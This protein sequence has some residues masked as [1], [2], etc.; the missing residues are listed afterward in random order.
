MSRLGEK[1]AQVRT[2]K[3][4]TQKVLAKK[5]GVAESFIKDIELGRKV[6]NETLMEKVSKVLGEEVNDVSMSFDDVVEAE[7]RVAVE[8]KPK[9]KTLEK[10]DNQWSD[11][12]SSVL[13][14]VPVYGYDLNK[15]IDTKQLPVVS[16]KINGYTPDKVI[17]LKIENDDMLSFRIAEGDIAF[18]NL[19][20]EIENNTICLVECRG[21]RCLRQIKKLDS[22]KVLLISNKNSLRADAFSKKEVKVIAKLNYVE[23]KL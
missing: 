20:G 1:I 12:F 10:I 17:F 14:S 4:L 8:V 2:K 18:A 22:D 19:T 11:A 3:G 21:E 16:N 23:L 7:E 6:V 9:Y 13:R 15:A 5:L